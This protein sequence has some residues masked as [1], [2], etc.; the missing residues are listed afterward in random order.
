MKRFLIFLSVSIL[1][2]VIHFQLNACTNYIITKGASAD[3]SVMISYAADSH[4]LY[5]ELYYSPAKDYPKDAWLDIT[6]WDTGK[7]LGKIKQVMHTY[8]V[9][10]NM[11]ENQV[12]IGETTFG[13]RSELLDTLG[14]IDYGSLIYI[15]LQR[16]KSAR[17]AIKVM[18]SLAMEYGYASEG[19]SFS[20]SDKNEAWILEMIGKGVGKKGAIWVARRIPD[21]YIC[22]HANH[23]RITNIPMNDPENCL[24]APDVISFA[25]EKGYYQGEDKDF[26]F[27]DA[28]AP[29]DFEG[30]RFCEVRVWSMFR[31]VNKD[32]DQ[33]LDYVKGINNQHRLP[34]WIKPDR[35]ITLH[36]MMMFMRDHL[37]GTELDMTKDYGAGPFGL[38][39]RWRPLTWKVNGVAYCNERAT[40]TQQTGFSFIAQSRSWLP[41]QIGGIDW[42]GVDDAAS[43]VYSP[44][45]SSMTRVPETFAVGNGDMLTYSDNSAFWT[46]NYVSNFCYLRYNVMIEDVKK[47]QGE[48]ETKYMNQTHSVDSIALQYFKKKPAKAVSYLTDYSVNTGNQTVARWK[49]LGHYLLVK[50]MDGNIK[51]EKD[52]KFARTKYNMPVYP[53]QPGYPEWFLENIVKDTQ[54]KLKVQESH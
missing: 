16:S 10:G 40:A 15:S 47:V 11:N 1:F 37:E 34:L 21:G 39:Y 44:M 18:T 3:G 17:E 27:C 4:T 22:G 41:D 35:K 14:G 12:A 28:Y 46:F 8:S 6:E 51:V 24:Y 42:F 49:E 26:I 25:R 48:L 29:L 33:Y 13:G 43:T 32:M 5:G 53:L 7:P 30:A 2:S 38:P 45:Y 36:D 52:G 50:Y 31:K 19:E 23:A 54:D 20:I 9:V